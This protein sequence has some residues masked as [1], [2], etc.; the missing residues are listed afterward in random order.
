MCL[1]A[2]TTSAPRRAMVSSG[3][4]TNTWSRQHE[5]DC[6]RFRFHSLLFS[7][8]LQ[9]NNNNNNNNSHELLIQKMGSMRGQFVQRLQALYRSIDVLES[10]RREGIEQKYR[11]VIENS[12]LIIHHLV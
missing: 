5:L 10:Q 6:L 9:T 8:K 1:V 2:M 12:I 11:I 3:T 7:F 4:Q